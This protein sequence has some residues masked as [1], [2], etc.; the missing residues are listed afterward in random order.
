VPA[1]KFNVQ[2]VRAMRMNKRPKFKYQKQRKGKKHIWYG[3]IN[4]TSKE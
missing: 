4:Y 3:G 1:M 2:K